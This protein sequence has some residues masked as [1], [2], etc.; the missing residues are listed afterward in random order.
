[1]IMAL[2]PQAEALLNEMKNAGALPIESMTVSEGRLDGL[3]FLGLQGVPEPVA[4][5][6]HRFVPGPT[7]DLPVRVYYPEG[8]GPFGALVQFH[9][10]GWVICNLD[11]NDVP[12]RALANRSGCVVVAVNYQKA[13]EHKFPIPLDD[14]YAT[15]CWV[16]EHAAELNIDPARIG[17]A[18]DSSGGNLAAA[19][20]LRARDEGGPALAFQLLIYPPT[21]HELDTPSYLSFG[22]GF[23]LQRE[24]MRWFWNHYLADPADGKNPLASPLLA[25]DLSG[26]PPALI[27]TAGF[28]PLRDDGERYADRLRAAGVPVTLSRYEG[29]IHAF[30]LM[31]GVFDEAKRLFDEAG[32]AVRS[33]LNTQ[34]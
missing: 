20:C 6:E 33:A 9:G 24:S 31:D 10:S 14:C 25:E 30:Y 21:S 34:P 11:I 2:D 7:A 23:G 5:I 32:L 4:R 17:V 1:M 8:D 18:G 29:M 27:V 16:A 19:V 12:A 28:D 13:P 15:A 26:L 22:E 3:N